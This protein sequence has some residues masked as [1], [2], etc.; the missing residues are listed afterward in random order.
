MMVKIF[1]LFL[2][3][4]VLPGCG[5]KQI[6]TSLNKQQLTS[7]QDEIEQL[8]K[9]LGKARA[10]YLSEW[11]ISERKVL[12]VAVLYV[13]RELQD[14]GNWKNYQVQ[15]DRSLRAS[16][17]WQPRTS[18]VISS[19]RDL[20]TDRRYLAF[21]N[22]HDFDASTDLHVNWM[23]GRPSDVFIWPINS[24]EARFVD[25]FLAGQSGTKEE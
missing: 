22:D 10:D 20:D 19:R 16:S 5:E 8:I 17:R 15:V 3:V 12:L 21:L 6:V 18:V 14:A 24:P 25:A 1:Y 13:K 11:A 9:R 2:L 4:L 7:T 23:G